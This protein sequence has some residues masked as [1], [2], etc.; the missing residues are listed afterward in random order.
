MHRRNNPSRGRKR[1]PSNPRQQAQIQ[2]P[3]STTTAAIRN[4]SSAG[5][6][7]GSTAKSSNTTVTTGRL[8]I[9]NNE[10]EVEAYMFFMAYTADPSVTGATRR[11]LMFSFNGGPGSAS[12]WLH[13]GALGPKR[14]KMLPEGE[15]PAPPFELIDNDSTWLD[16]TDMV[17]IDPVGTG[18]SRPA[19]KE[20]GSKF[21]N[22]QGDIQSIGEFIRLYLSRYERWQSPLFVIG[23]SYGTFRAAGLS[24]YLVGKGIALNGVLLIS[25]FLNFETL[26][27]S[28]GNENGYLLFLPTFTATAWYHKKLAPELQK[29]LRA[30]LDEVERWALTDYAA[31]L[32]KGDRLGDAER[33]EIAN[34]LAR[35]TGLSPVYVN[36]SNLRI[37]QPQFCAE[38]LRDRKLAVGRL[39]GRFTNQPLSGVSE[40]AFEDPA[41]SAIRPPY[42]ALFNNYIRRDLGF[43]TDM[44]YHIMGGIGGWD[45]TS[46]RN[47]DEDLRG[48]LLKNPYMKVFVA[49]GYY[50]MATPYFG[51]RY[52]LDHLEL[53][54]A[55]RA[56]ID[57]KYY[58]A[59]HMMYIRNEDLARLKQD[60]ARFL[61]SA[62]KSGAN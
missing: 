19:K 33:K 22:V 60:A 39:D 58:E 21:W 52:S 24:E 7:S 30:T 55:L 62:I 47:T 50:D 61:E 59:G 13:L 15:M 17:F 1:F 23:E 26:N 10:G 8:P 34:R 43:K 54:P 18:Y 32:A 38:L 56:N 4:P 36:N 35:Y 14:V 2:Q 29:D 49:A 37:N 42:T 6:K 20:L 28:R 51:A 41:M 3:W 46:S 25:T 31:A 44:E 9:R 5:T 48:A 45:H 40:M 53:N 57:M 11:P 16:M 27:T 12:V